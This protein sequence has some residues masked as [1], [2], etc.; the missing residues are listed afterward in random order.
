MRRVELNAK[1]I[2]EKEIFRKHISYNQSRNIFAF[3]SIKEKIS[4]VGR[5]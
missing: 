2:I 4:A 5:R 3:F 1:V